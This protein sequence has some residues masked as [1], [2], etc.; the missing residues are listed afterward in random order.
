MKLPGLN[1][2]EIVYS[3]Y[4]RRMKVT[5]LYANGLVGVVSLDCENRTAMWQRQWCIKKG[6]QFPLFKSEPNG[7]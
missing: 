5:A 2:G 4:G 6:G 1:I 3:R 7:N